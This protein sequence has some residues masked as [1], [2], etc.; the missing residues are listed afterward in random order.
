MNQK[1]KDAVQVILNELNN[2]S[3]QGR[4]DV[5]LTIVDTVRSDHRTLQQSFWN[6]LLVAQLLY[7]DSRYDARNEAAVGWAKEVKALATKHNLD[8]GCLPFI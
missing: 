8:I 1:V 3:S 5:A 7:A 6:A 2:I 4:K